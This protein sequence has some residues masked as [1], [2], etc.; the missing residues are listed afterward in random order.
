MRLSGFL[1]RTCVL[2]AISGSQIAA[3]PVAQSK[4][5]DKKTV[6][7]GEVNRIALEMPIPFNPPAMRRRVYGVVKVQ[8]WINKKGDVIRTLVAS[9]PKPL[10][11]AAVQSA[12]GTKFAPNLGDCPSCRY[13]TGFLTYTFVKQD[14]SRPNNE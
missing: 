7:L 14:F 4:Q 2:V 3:A 8:V 13:V 6:D 1:L 11:R 10:R 12:A 9:G 5:Y